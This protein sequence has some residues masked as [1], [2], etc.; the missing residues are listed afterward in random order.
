MR[1]EGN[2]RLRVFLH[3]WRKSFLFSRRRNIR[4][5]FPFSLSQYLLPQTGR[6]Y[7]NWRE[8]SGSQTNACFSFCGISVARLPS[9][10]NH[11]LDFP[12]SFPQDLFALNQIVDPTEPFELLLGFSAFCP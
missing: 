5:W 9:G 11:L 7:L 3:K 4:P 6:N 12:L 1:L 2:T 8:L 10:R